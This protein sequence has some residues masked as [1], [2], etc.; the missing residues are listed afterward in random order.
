MYYTAV[1]CTHVGA[2]YI[3]SEHNNNIIPIKESKEKHQC[4]YRL[5]DAMVYAEVC[6][7]HNNRNRNIC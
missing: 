7:M 1:Q 5:L 6:A 3:L 2:K 4:K